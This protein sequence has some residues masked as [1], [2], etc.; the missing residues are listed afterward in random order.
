MK[1]CQ[2]MR[3]LKKAKPGVLPLSHYLVEFRE[4]GKISAMGNSRQKTATDKRRTIHLSH[5]LSKI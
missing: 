1:I 5:S 3:F 4:N 2:K